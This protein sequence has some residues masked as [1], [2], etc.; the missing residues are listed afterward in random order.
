MH[1]IARA[2]LVEFWSRHPEAQAPLQMWYRIVRISRWR[3]FADLRR[4]FPSADFVGRLTVFNLA[5]NNFRLIA[6][7]DY[8]YRKVFIRSILTHADYTKAYWKRDPWF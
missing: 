6:Y 1:I 7:I 2:R 4:S 5:G 3:H 8:K